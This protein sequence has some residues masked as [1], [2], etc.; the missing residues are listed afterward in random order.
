MWVNWI[1]TVESQK[2]QTYYLLDILTSI[3]HFK[4]RVYKTV[5]DKFVQRANE[6]SEKK[7]FP[8]ASRAKNKTSEFQ[9]HRVDVEVNSC[10]ALASVS[11][12]W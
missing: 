4:G 10:L 9:N 2:N 5:T 8:H 3:L 6:L 7:K 1:Y 11:V 12:S